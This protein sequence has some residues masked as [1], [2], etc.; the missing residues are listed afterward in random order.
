MNE[1]FSVFLVAILFVGQAALIHWGWAHKIRQKAKYGF[2]LAVGG[3]LYRIT[4]DEGESLDR[5]VEALSNGMRAWVL[6][7]LAS[8]PR[9]REGLQRLLKTLNPELSIP[10]IDVLYGKGTTEDSTVVGGG[11]RTSGDTGEKG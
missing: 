3:R 2:R 7:K 11:M 4:L 6:Q 5:D 10:E 8:D 9:T 1:G